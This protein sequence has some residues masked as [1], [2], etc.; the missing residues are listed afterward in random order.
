MSRPLLHLKWIEEKY[1][2]IDEANNKHANPYNTHTRLA[3]KENSS[4][5]A[6]GITA[7]YAHAIALRSR[8]SCYPLTSLA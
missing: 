5:G 1:I 6:V 4:A 3:I 7:F 8:I 2:Q